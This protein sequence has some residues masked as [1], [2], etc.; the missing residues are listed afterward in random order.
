M[1][2][3]ERRTPRVSRLFLT[4]YVIK[5]GEEQKTPVSMGRTL[6]VSPTGVGMEVFQVLTVGS[7]MDLEFDLQD[8]LLTVKGTVVHIRP[9]GDDR[10]V[11]GIRFDEPQEKLAALLNR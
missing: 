2:D 3:K 11:V 4:S 5:E 8:T 10:H 7:A 9:E 6:D 1:N